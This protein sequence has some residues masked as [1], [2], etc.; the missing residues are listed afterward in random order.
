VVGFFT[1]VL[2][3]KQHY[4]ERRKY[5]G[6]LCVALYMLAKC[7][8]L[9]IRKALKGLII[10]SS[11]DGKEML[12]TGAE[13]TTCQSAWVRPIA[14]D[15]DMQGRGLGTAMLE[16]CI[17]RAGDL[18]LKEVIAGVDKRNLRAIRTHEKLAFVRTGQTPSYYI[19]TRKVDAREKPTLQ[20]Q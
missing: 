6:G 7:P 1:L 14:V 10:M 16:F 17:Q 8:K 2:D 3:I 18:G 13:G 4:K 5:R 11:N 12:G 19:Y 15:P 9:L 20:I